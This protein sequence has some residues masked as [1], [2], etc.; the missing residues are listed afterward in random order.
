MYCVHLVS[1]CFDGFCDPV[2]TV[3]LNTGHTVA[4]VVQE[5][6][7]TLDVTLNLLECVKRL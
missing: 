2:S 1:Y 5:F 6:F 7:E 3:F 4:E